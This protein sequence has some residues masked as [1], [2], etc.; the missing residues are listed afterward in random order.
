MEQQEVA[1]QMTPGR[2]DV[3]GGDEEGLGGESLP[4]CS[5]SRGEI[6][7]PA[8]AA[9]RKELPLAGVD[10]NPNPI[11]AT[12]GL[13]WLPP[14]SGRFACAQGLARPVAGRME[15]SV[16]QTPCVSSGEELGQPEGAW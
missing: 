14:G 5:S 7:N 8:D 12:A 2:N 3:K 16:S 11:A 4:G 15:S 10:T 9:P 1:R 6:R 13:A